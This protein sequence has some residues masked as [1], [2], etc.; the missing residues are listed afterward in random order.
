MTE[1]CSKL[2]DQDWGV[3][4]TDQAH[5]TVDWCC[6]RWESWHECCSSIGSY[7]DEIDIVNDFVAHFLESY[8]VTPTG[9]SE[10]NLDGYVKNVIE[11]VK[12]NLLAKA[13]EY[14]LVGKKDE[15]KKD[16]GWCAKCTSACF[17]CIG[18]CFKKDAEEKKV[19]K[20]ICRFIK[21]FKSR[22]LLASERIKCFYYETKGSSL[23]PSEER[24]YYANFCTDY[25]GVDYREVCHGNAI[26]SYKF[27]NHRLISPENPDGKDCR[28]RELER[29][30]VGVPRCIVPERIRAINRMLALKVR[31]SHEQWRDMIGGPV[32]LGHLTTEKIQA[33]IK[34]KR[35]CARNCL[36][37]CT[38]FLIIGSFLFIFIQSV[39]EY[40]K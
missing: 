3:D 9:P 4:E 11:D 21:D 40:R 19:P 27:D 22:Y 13:E 17:N 24:D 5:S 23:G 34:N 7:K 31:M 14:F 8:K 39:I 25:Y 6:C 16:E 29:N 10:L 20:Y 33:K 12:K 18:A 30:L 32:N 15:E 36:N 38:V 26:G 35:V 37:L 1:V 2:L 28:L